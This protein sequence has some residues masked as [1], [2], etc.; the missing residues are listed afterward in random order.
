VGTASYDARVEPDVRFLRETT[1]PGYEHGELTVR[2]I[3]LF[4][5]CGGLTVGIA[6]AARQLGVALEV[7]LAVE[8]DEAIA[9]VFEANFTKATVAQEPV[10][11]LI[12]GELGESFTSRESLLVAD[13]GVVHWLQGGPPC[14]G[15]SDLNNHTRR[16]DRRNAF[17]LRMARAAEIF[18]PQVVVIENVP[19]VRHDVGGVVGETRGHL[20]S[21]GYMVADDVIA[22]DA[23]GVPQRRRR[24]TLIGLRGLDLDPAAVLSG[25]DSDG[26]ERDLAWAIGDLVGAEGSE[27][28][29]PSRVTATNAERIAWLHAK[30]ERKD[31][32]NSRRPKCHQGDHSYRSMYGKLM[33]NEP[34]QTITSGFGSMGQGRYVH[35][36]EPRTLTPHE[37]A[38]IQFFPDWF[39]F[40]AGGLETRRSLWATM[41]GNAVPPK[42]TMDLGRVL[43]P[44]LDLDG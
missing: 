26:T 44:H 4:A 39:D 15:H 37:A 10:E 18:E 25:L 3:D 42:L 36:S 27:L 2:V 5:G 35:P 9:K 8:F 24:H 19:G 21:L 43:L 17:Y 16:S 38:R 23:L 33:W 7:P 14:Q 22:L 28:D 1:R 40:T 20:E 30:P 32:P 11:S 12:D 13:T 31:L 6:E 34:A 41:I 29:V